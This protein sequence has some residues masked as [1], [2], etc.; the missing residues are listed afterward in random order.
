MGKGGGKKSAAARAAANR[1]LADNRLARLALESTH[2]R[3]GMGKAAYSPGLI[4][5]ALQAMEKA[6]TIYLEILPETHPTFSI[7]YLNWGLI[8]YNQNKHYSCPIQQS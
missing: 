2:I 7:L 3:E 8:Y 5:E 1:L 4:G 6:E